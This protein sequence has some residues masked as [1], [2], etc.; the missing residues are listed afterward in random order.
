MKGGVQ[1][2]PG[3]WQVPGRDHSAL[4]LPTGP[5]HCPGNTWPTAAQ[6]HPS[7]PTTLT[8]KGAVPAAVCLPCEWRMW[9]LELPTSAPLTPRHSHPSCFAPPVSPVAL[10]LSL[11]AHKPQG[12]SLHSQAQ[13]LTAPYQRAPALGPERIS[14]FTRPWPGRK[15][16]VQALDCE[17]PH[18]FL[19]VVLSQVLILPSSHCPAGHLG[20]HRRPRLGNCSFLLV[21]IDISIFVT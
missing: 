9:W 1:P 8:S 17:R 15:G 12:R 21:T 20:G 10:H 2:G 3:S 7:R 5:G 19:S 14:P 16:K 18:P 13:R 11:P 6:A 4:L